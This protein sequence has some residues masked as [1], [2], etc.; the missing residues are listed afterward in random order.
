MIN[1]TLKISILWTSEIFNSFLYSQRVH[2]SRNLRVGNEVRVAERHSWKLDFA[3]WSKVCVD[4]NPCRVWFVPH[5]KRGHQSNRAKK[6]E[7]RSNSP[8]NAGHF[9]STRIVDVFDAWRSS[10]NLSFDFKFC[11]KLPWIDVV[12]EN[13]SQVAEKARLKILSCFS[14]FFWAVLLAIAIVHASSPKSTA[15]ESLE[16]FEWVSEKIDIPIVR[17]IIDRNNCKFQ[18]QSGLSNCGQPKI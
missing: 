14:G 13:W 6:A 9:V 10:K 11:K 12:D 3:D 7:Y 5:Q 16:M 17:C 8:E 15:K 4:V 2:Q 18:F 1:F